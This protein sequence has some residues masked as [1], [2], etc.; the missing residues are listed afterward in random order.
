MG[1]NAPELAKLPAIAKAFG[2]KVAALFDDEKAE[3]QAAKAK[4]IANRRSV[5]LQK[6]LEKLKPNEQQLDLKQFEVLAGQK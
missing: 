4:S 5:K 3:A 1:I 6:A 2:V